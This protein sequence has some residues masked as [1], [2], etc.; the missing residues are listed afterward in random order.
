MGFL[1]FLSPALTVATGAAGAYEQGKTERAATEQKN[2]LTMLAQLR[3]A[4]QD[5]EKRTMDA[6]NVQHLG[7]QTRLYGAQADKAERPEQETFGDF[8]NL[9]L[10]GTPSVV[11]RGNRGT[12]RPVTGAAPYQ[13]D[14]NPL[15]GSADWIKAKDEEARIT[16]KYRRDP[17]AVL[18]S[19]TDEHGNPRFLRYDEATN[20]MIPVQGGAPKQAIGG[21][22]GGAGAKAPLDDMLDRYEELQAHADDISSGKFKPTRAMQTKEG[23]D[24]AIAIGN[25]KGQ[26]AP[27]KAMGVS[28][29]QSMLP[30]ALGGVDTQSADYRR[31]Q[32]LMNSTRAM[33]DDVAKVFK[34]RQNEDAVLREVALGQITPDDFG[35]PQQIKQKMDRI[36]NV[37][38]LAALTDPQQASAADPERLFKITGYRPAPSAGR[39]G[40]GGG[41]TGGAKKPITA[42]GAAA[43]RAANY[44]DAEIAAKYTVVQP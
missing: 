13:P 9:N 33:G 43:L 17:K 31:F 18:Q 44:S 37:V 5:A 22:G 11:Q 41:A 32:N 14:K 12:V 36:K 15:M 28:T 23:A 4:Q 42:A 2:T 25:A 7:A 19:G 35:N 21:G 38:K 16:A 30:S 34:G 10:N 8:E 26:A 40:A 3:Q 24:Y 39:G 1:D 27:F 29:A 6:A 20:S